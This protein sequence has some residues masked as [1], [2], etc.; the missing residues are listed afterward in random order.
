MG[1][2]LVKSLSALVRGVSYYIRVRGA[3]KVVRDTQ[4]SGLTPIGGQYITTAYPKPPEDTWVLLPWRRSYALQE[5]LP[6][7]A[8]EVD[9][10]G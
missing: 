9:S 4:E 10:T 2:G 3:Q 1:W 6:G 5:V 8:G 7:H